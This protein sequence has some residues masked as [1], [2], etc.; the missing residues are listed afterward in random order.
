MLSTLLDIPRSTGK[1]APLFKNGLKQKL[2]DNFI[3]LKR[4]GGG[5]DQ[6]RG[7][8]REGVG[9]RRREGD[10]RGRMGREGKKPQADKL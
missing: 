7:G 3:S 4:R 9:K 6:E 1:R 2:K 5:R 8:G 10:G